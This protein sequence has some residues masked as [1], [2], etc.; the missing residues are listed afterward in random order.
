[1]NKLL[2]AVMMAVGGLMVAG[3]ATVKYAR[4]PVGKLEGRGALEWIAAD[5]FIFRPDP[6][7]PLR[8]TRANGKGIIQPKLMYT[9]GG[10]IP[11][12]FWGLRGYSPWGYGPAYLIHDW[13]FAA[14]HCGLPDYAPYTVDTAA[15][16]M[17]E[18]MKTL[19]ET[20]TNV[21][22]NASLLYVMDIAVRTK[23]AK[24]FWDTGACSL[25]P[26]IYMTKPGPESP[27]AFMG[28]KPQWVQVYDFRAG[29]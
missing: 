11:R 19:M 16:V 5:K 15:D 9:D 7:D 6:A 13:L 23:T 21:L 20:N 25:P 14:H 24:T 8:F 4:T 3:C 2:A 28:T 29:K 26:A 1:M 22:K 17:S 18:C 10:S 27:T 12:F